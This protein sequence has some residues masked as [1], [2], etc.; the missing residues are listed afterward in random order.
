LLR[1]SL[2]EAVRFDPAGKPLWRE[3]LRT[4]L[5]AGALDAELAALLE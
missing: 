1:L 5:P 2:G 3:W 4:R